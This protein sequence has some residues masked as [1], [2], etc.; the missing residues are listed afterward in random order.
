[1]QKIC[2]YTKK[3]ANTRKGMQV[4]RKSTGTD[5][6]QCLFRW[7]VR[8]LPYNPAVETRKITRE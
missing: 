2:K 4:T 7:Q 6:G 5:R 8:S 3:Y 1:M